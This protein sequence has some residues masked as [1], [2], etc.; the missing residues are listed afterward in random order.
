MAK[1]P[2][3]GGYM[4]HPASCLIRRETTGV[5]GQQLSATER[6]DLQAHLS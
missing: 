1:V 3:K 4:G 5:K 6:E 2:C